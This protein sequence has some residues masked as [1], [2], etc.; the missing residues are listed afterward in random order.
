MISFDHR[1]GKSEFFKEAKKTL[2]KWFAIDNYIE[3]GNSN[4]I[5]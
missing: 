3:Q 1:I 5:T 4:I 2:N